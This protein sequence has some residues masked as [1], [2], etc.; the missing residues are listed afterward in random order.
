MNTNTAVIA[1]PIRATEKDLRR[2]KAIEA[3]LTQPLGV[4]PSETGDPIRSVSI[5]FFQ[6]LSPLLKPE[7]SVKA[8]RRAIGAYVRS[9]RYYLSCSHEGAMRHDGDGNPVEPVSDADRQN[10]HKWLQT[11]IQQTSQ[12]PE[13]G[14]VTST[15]P[16]AENKRDLIRASLLGRLRS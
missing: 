13:P 3:L 2:S 15:V 9:K 16:A 1:K 10:A 5:G 6:Q 12:A 7:A 14:I 11:F 4:L 8:L